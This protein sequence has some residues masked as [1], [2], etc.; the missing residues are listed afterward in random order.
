[1]L[2]FCFKRSYLKMRVAMQ[3]KP[4]F[5]IITLIVLL[6]CGITTHDNQGSA[7]TSSNNL[8]PENASVADVPEVIQPDWEELWRT[9]DDIH[10]DY[11]LADPRFIDVHD[12][13]VLVGDFRGERPLWIF[14]A[15]DGSFEQHVGE[16]GS[17]PGQIEWLG[18]F[19]IIQDE[20]IALRDV[21][22]Q[23]LSIFDRD[24][25]TFMHRVNVPVPFQ[26]GIGNAKIVRRPS[27][28]NV[29]AHAHALQINE[30][31]R[32]VIDELAWEVQLSEFGDAFVPFE[33]NFVAKKG[34]TVLDEGTAYMGFEHASHIVAISE[35]GEVVFNT[36]APHDVN[37]P[38]FLGAREGVDMMEPPRNV[39]PTM[40]LRLDTDNQ[41]VYALHSGA[42]V[43]EEND[44]QDVLTSTRV[45]VFDKETGAY[46]FQFTLP[47]PVHDLEIDSDRVYLLALS[48]GG[49]V[50][51]EKPE[52][53]L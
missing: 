27:D 28:P 19:H 14:N 51:F 9:A 42:V 47:F 24:T 15:T 36:S 50:A 44:M 7:Y 43:N 22:N 12:G 38:D 40:T 34:P 4:L 30:D 45:D 6:C 18:S 49:A 41:Y 20:Y 23:L 52:M 32:I 13:A 37:P 21:Q 2:L 39:Y 10:P 31:E 8:N 5:A 35:T 1:M 46:Q 17:G 16:E 25:G 48:Q 53:L 29:L 11:F 3:T 26:P 33:E